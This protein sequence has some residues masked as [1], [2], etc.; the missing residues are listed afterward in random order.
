MFEYFIIVLL[1]LSQFVLCCSPLPC[2]PPSGYCRSVPCFHG[3]SSILFVCL[4]CWLGSSYRWN[5]MVFVPHLL[6][7]FT[8]HNTLQFHSC[9]PEGWELLSFC[10]V[11]FHCVD[12][13]QLFDPLIYWWAPKLFP[14]L[15][16]YKLCCYE[17]WGAY[18]LSNWC[19]KILRV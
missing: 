6:A 5:L 13:P 4:F 17:H 2:T 3:S 1:Q 9:C 8:Y 16:Y 15:S 19:F 18:V 7:Y 11:V 12:V 10:C 14:A